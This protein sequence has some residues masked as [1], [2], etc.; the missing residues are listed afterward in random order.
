MTGSRRI[1]DDLAWQSS[2]N[3][4]LC[5]VGASNAF[6]IDGPDVLTGSAI[7]NGQVTFSS[8]GGCVQQASSAW[9]AG[10]GMPKCQMDL[11]SITITLHRRRGRAAA[12]FG[13]P[14]A[15]GER[16]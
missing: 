15:A 9:L 16:G 4:V 12:S 5:S 14:G 7:A 2:E 13:W 10:S 11:L 1:G 8:V 3:L 6:G